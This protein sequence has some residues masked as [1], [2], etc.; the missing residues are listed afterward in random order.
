VDDLA[1]CLRIACERDGRAI[2]V[3]ELNGRHF[4]N[5]AS[6]GFGAEITASTPIQLKKMLGGGAY[7][8]MGLIKAMQLSPYFGRLVL[9]G[10]EVIAGGML[11]MAVGNNRLAGGGFNVA[12]LAKLDDGL[13]DLVV[14][15]WEKGMNLAKLPA[16]LEDPLNPANEILFY[17]QLPAFEIQSDE[18]LHCNLDGEPILKKK[19]RFKALPRKLNVAF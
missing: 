16:E 6:A 9:P 15:R 8:I 13:L 2:D 1:A 18:K 14:I 3:G 5:V 4:I 7:S 12:P 10:G 11:F 17:R 19:F